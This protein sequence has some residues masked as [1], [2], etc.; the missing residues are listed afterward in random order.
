MQTMYFHWHV[1]IV[2][3]TPSIQLTNL[4][5]NP[6]IISPSES[7]GKHQNIRLVNWRVI[8]DKTDPL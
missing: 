6:L 3:I 4:H 5:G 2:L 7:K 8:R 1:E